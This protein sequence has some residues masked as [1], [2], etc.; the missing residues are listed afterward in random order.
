MDNSTMERLQAK[1]PEARFLH[2]LTEDYQQAPRVAQAL[3]AE[4]QDCLLGH[5]ATLRPGQ[6]RVILVR[7]DAGHGR[8]LDE[9]ARQEVTWTLDAGQEDLEVLQAHGSIALRRV[10]IQRL[11]DEALDQGA[12]ATQEDL[13]Q[14][15]QVSVRTIKRDCKELRKEVFLP[16]RG[17][18]QGI[19]RGQTHKAQ[20]VGR[21]LRGETYDQLQLHS[22]HSLASIQRYVQAFVRVVDLH[23]RGFSES[24]TA[25]LLGM[26]EAL[27]REYLAVYDQHPEAEYRQRLTEQIER[28]GRAPQAKK[29]AQ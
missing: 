9:T 18:L 10:R 17:K 6:I 24:E 26:G 3:L 27:V 29:G 20:I 25:L 12:A 28:L 19:G 4:A 21:W 7:Q 15:L 11:L 1:T 23:C 2:V 16:L 13:A 8:S 22:R 5:G 14:V